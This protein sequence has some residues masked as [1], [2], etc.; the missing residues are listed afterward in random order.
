MQYD[1]CIAQRTIK[2]RKIGTNIRFVLNFK[3]CG[4]ITITLEDVEYR[5]LY[6]GKRHYELSNH[7]GNVQVVISDKRISVCYTELEVEYFKA[8]VL[9]AMDY[10]P[11]GMMMPDRQ[12]YAGSDSSIAVFGFQGQEKLDEASGPGNLILFKYRI[13]DPRIGKFLSVD[14]YILKYPWS[15]PYAFCGNRVIDGIDFEGLEFTK[16]LSKAEVEARINFLKTNP[17]S[18]NQ[19][20]AGTCVI[21]A[22]TYLWILKDPEGFAKAAMTLYEKGEVQVNDYDIDPDDHLFDVN[23]IDNPD[24]YHGNGAAYSADWMILSSIQDAQNVFYDFDGVS[25]DEVGAG[26]YMSDAAEL[27]KDLI[28]YKNV[29]KT[30]FS[31]LTG[32]QTMD[33]INL[34]SKE[35]NAIYLDIDAH[36]FDKTL[37]DERSFHGVSFISGSY[38]TYNDASGNVRHV[39]Q[40]QTW[41]K[42]KT[43]DASDEDMGKYIRGAVYGNDNEEK[44]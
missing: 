16:Y 7:L 36:I 9:S 8:E 23:P 25:S 29:T 22:V 37:Y 40:V 13:Y 43:I 39:F 31:G 34:K 32:R 26:N 4:E 35:G 18:I 20:G 42:T 38:S 1:L 41:G 3:W 27:M 12:W 17:I 6:R 2:A 24:V 28:G 19:G 14:P 30:E 33:E 15:S 21:A 5:S 10:Y 11:F 44:K